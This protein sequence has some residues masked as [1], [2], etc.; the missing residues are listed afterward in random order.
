M[1]KGV[2]RP[3]ASTV[4]GNMRHMHFA[5]VLPDVYQILGGAMSSLQ[6]DK[7]QTS[8]KAGSD[9]KP[10]STDAVAL[11][12]LFAVLEI[13]EP[14]DEVETTPQPAK[15]TSPSRPATITYEL[16]D[17]MD[18][19]EVCFIL[20]C[21]FNDFQEVRTQIRQSWADYIFWDGGSS[22]RGDHDQCCNGDVAAG[23]D[24]APRK[25]SPK[26]ISS[27]ATRKSHVSSY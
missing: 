15:S 14:E 9:E 24:C 16:G 21:F 25:P 8:A 17:E 11:S 3:E 27:M 19:E 26:N 18:G 7:E 23:R 22:R 20:Y 4:T 13:E 10:T 2:R 1:R 6:V 5:N 12:N